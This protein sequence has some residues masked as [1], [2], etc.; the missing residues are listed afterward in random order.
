MNLNFKEGNNKPYIDKFNFVSNIHYYTIN[1]IIFLNKK[2]IKDVVKEL[3]NEN[4][5]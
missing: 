5:L 1:G 4:T 3:K 2:T